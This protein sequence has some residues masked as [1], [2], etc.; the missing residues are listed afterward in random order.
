MEGFEMTG[1]DKDKNKLSQK[2][3]LWLWRP[4]EGGY[5][6][7][8][9][10][11]PKEA[12]EKVTGRALYTNDVYLPGM[13]YVKVFHSPYAHARI[14]KMDTSKAEALPGVWAVIRYDD[15]EID[16]SDPYQPVLGFMWFW[17]QNSI[18]PDTADYQGVRLGALIIAES[19]QICDHALKL[20]GE[21]I[22][23]EQL[24]FIL[25]PERAIQPDAPLL[26]PE[27][28]S[29]NNIWKDAVILDQ[30]DVE[31]GFASSDYVVEFTEIKNEDDVWAGVEP[32]CM[33]VQWVGDNLEFWYHG[34]RIGVDVNFISA[35][36]YKND[37]K[38]P[39]KVKAHTPFNGGTFG[40]NA[41]GLACHL[42]RY[43]AIAARKTMRPVK[44]VDDYSM[45]WEGNSFETGI[46]RYKVGFNNDGTIIAIKI[47]IY[48]KNGLPITS[49]FIDTLKT[50]N[51]YVHSTHTYWNRPHES[52]WKDG[53]ANCTLVNL[54]INKV[55]ACLNMDPIKVQMINDGA[56]GH[57]MAW[58]D[59]HVKKPYGMPLRD[60]LKEVVEA[61]KKAFDWDRKWHP[62]GAR[63]LPN[64]RMHGVGFYAVAC[65]H[66]GARRGGVPGI[67]ISRD[68]TATLFYRRPDCGQSAL[69]AY[70]QIAADEIGLRYEDVKI[71][72]TDY[73][74]FDAVPPAGSMGS[75]FNTFNL[76][77]NARK[78][79][80]LLLEYVVNPS[81]E[82][83][84]AYGNAVP[85]AFIPFQGKKVEELDI[86]DGVIFEKAHPEN[87][88][89]VKR[90][91]SLQP[92]GL[93]AAAEGGSF[94]VG[95]K[96]PELPAVQ[97]KYTL[98][99][100]CVFVEVEVDTETGQVEV[101]KLVHPYDVGQSLN[102]DVN[103]QQLY[104]GAY[105]GVGVSATEAIFYDPHTGVRLNDNLLGYPVLTILDVGEI[106]A[107]IVE[108][109]LGWSAYGLCGCSEAGKA[110]TAAA[111]LVPAVYNAIGKWIEETPVTPERILRALGKA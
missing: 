7:R 75:S 89:L 111:I 50:P 71:E 15:P 83:M 92:R 102:P 86:R 33:V 104:G 18:L 69:T 5:I 105:P 12:P 57:D 27:R 26:H 82:A 22:E 100:Q 91:T 20:I 65:W 54:I 79:K 81:V 73:F 90:V 103:D 2:N 31:K 41:M 76:V 109:H 97:G 84:R 96:A 94:F 95:D 4:P 48:Q 40:G 108:T 64:G 70:C 59:E 38:Q 1:A 14:R 32:G 30:G 11:R 99:R 52:C 17:H 3:A 51:V 80:K 42:A 87:K 8:R 9:G 55:A 67:S 49:K 62:P 98:V 25:D 68:G 110:A 44:V 63:K 60:S 23:W 106:E 107:P 45:S 88:L 29:K 16:L 21:G 24:P 34:Q 61:G 74:Y 19:E 85:P 6:G 13:L 10:L 53:A 93:E 56:Y 101:T 78:M 58:L 37:I 46:A 36:V 72:F 77:I 39:K 66:T 47:D 35:P 28:N 43:A